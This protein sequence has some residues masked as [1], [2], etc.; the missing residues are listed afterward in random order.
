MHKVACD[1]LCLPSRTHGKQLDSNYLMGN[2]IYVRVSEI[3]DITN[4]G[5]A[6][7]RSGAASLKG[8][9]GI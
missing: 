7:N 2:G 9:L 3:P 5:D 8:A 1:F 4:G 6:G